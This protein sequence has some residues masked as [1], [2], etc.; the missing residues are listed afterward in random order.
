MDTCKRCSIG[1]NRNDLPGREKALPKLSVTLRKEDHPR[2]Y[3]R[4]VFLPEGWIKT[5]VIEPDVAI[6]GE[7]C[8]EIVEPV[9]PFVGISFRLPLDHHP[10]RVGL[11]FHEHSTVKIGRKII[12]PSSDDR[13]AVG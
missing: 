3:A 7:Y 11:V 13:A 10:L 5:V 1:E 4:A 12:V 6:G 8:L 9:F 2:R